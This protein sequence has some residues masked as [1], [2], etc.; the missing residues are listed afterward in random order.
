MHFI[1]KLLIPGKSAESKLYF[2]GQKNFI[3]SNTCILKRQTRIDKINK[4]EFEG[5][6]MLFN[7]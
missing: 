4:I 2:F 1:S 7:D 6:N 3:D 5:L